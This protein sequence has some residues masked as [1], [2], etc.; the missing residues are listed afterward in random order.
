[1]FYWEAVGDDGAIY[2][3]PWVNGPDACASGFTCEITLD[4]DVNDG[5]K[6]VELRWDD[7][8]D[9]VS[10]SIEGVY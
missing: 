10:C 2:S 6:L 9:Q 3:T 7:I 4:F 5:T 8:F 1:M